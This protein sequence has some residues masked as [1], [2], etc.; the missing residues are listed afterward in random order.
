MGQGNNAYVFPGVALGIIAS[1][2]SRVTDDMFMIAAQTLSKLVSDE[3]LAQ[4]T[5]F[6]P[7]SDIRKVSFE[8]AKAVAKEAFEQGFARQVEPKDIGDL[9][10]DSQFDH[11][12]NRYYHSSVFDDLER[13]FGGQK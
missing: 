11:T 13:D 10:R 2:S 3:M 6:P 1:K 5:V 8:I 4:G 7:L 9:I 12:Y